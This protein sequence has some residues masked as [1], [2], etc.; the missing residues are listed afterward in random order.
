MWWSEW[1]GKAGEISLRHGVPEAGDE[2]GEADESSGRARPALPV[3][4]LHAVRS[5]AG[6]IGFLVFVWAR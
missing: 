4:C 6:V 5:V 2:G 1:G 3:G